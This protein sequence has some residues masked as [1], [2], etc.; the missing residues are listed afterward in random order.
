MPETYRDTAQRPK[1]MAAR[2]RLLVVLPAI[3]MIGTAPAI[4]QS[5]YSFE[6]EQACTSDAFRLCSEFIP[7]VSRITACMQA[8]QDQ[9]SPR[10]AK[11]F[12][13]GRDRHLN[14]ADQQLHRDPVQHPYVE[15]PYREQPYIEHRDQ[16]E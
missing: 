1:M 4:S 7:D 13:D 16:D 10:C 3:S 12:V 11:M 15:Q 2:L 9:L 14:D 8:K 6:E 5:N